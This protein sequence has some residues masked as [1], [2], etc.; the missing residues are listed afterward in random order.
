M[1]FSG[2][3]TGFIAGVMGWG[4]GRELEEQGRLNPPQYVGVALRR[5]FVRGA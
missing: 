3:A 4:Q 1:S 2:E 5:F